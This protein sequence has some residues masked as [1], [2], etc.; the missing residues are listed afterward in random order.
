MAKVINSVALEPLNKSLGLAGAGDSQTELLDGVVDQVIEVG[1]IA[2]RGLTLAG[3]EGIFRIVMRTIHAGAGDEATSFQPY[4]IGATGL[5]APFP[6]P[7]PAGLDFWLIGASIQTDA[8]NA[9]DAAVIRLT[10]V[11]QGFGLDSAAAA[12][13]STAVF[14]LANWTGVSS[15]IAPPFGISSGTTSPYKKINMRI[16]RK[17]AIASPFIVCETQALGAAEFDF[18]LMCG[19]FPSAL[20]QDLAF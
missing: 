11:Q 19:L 20:G 4:Q 15:A 10:N 12:V 5:I 13:V 3:T 7:V 1:Q 18:V 2:R 8:T 17:G 16:P 6:N 14:T 9:F